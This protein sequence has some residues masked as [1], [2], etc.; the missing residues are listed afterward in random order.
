MKK[1]LSL[2]TLLFFLNSFSQ[3]NTI[4]PYIL[5]IDAENSIYQFIKDKKQENIAFYF[6][7]LEN[8]KIKIHFTQKSRRSADSNRKLFINDKFYSVIFDLDYMFYVKAN[9]NFPLVSKFKDDREREFEIVK[10]P[11]IEERM[12]NRDLYAKD[13][14]KNII[15]WSTF[16]I[17]DED[18]KLIETNSK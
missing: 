7:R 9:D 18:G 14:I 4:I 15:D 5:D 17:V 6:E 13:G 12:K 1:I 10:I 2:L 11:N 3:K 8:E 16:W